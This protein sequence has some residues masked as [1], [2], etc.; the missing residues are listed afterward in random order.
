MSREAYAVIGLGVLAAVVLATDSLLRWTQLGAEFDVDWRMIMPSMGAS[1]LCLV[2]TLIAA[3]SYRLR[4]V[5]AGGIIA[6]GLLTVWGWAWLMASP[7]GRASWLSLAGGLLA[8]AAGTA[9]LYVRTA[10][11]PEDLVASSESA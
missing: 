10:A 11:P 4:L 6:I 7:I 9:L 2:V 1:I 3:L 8:L 5:A